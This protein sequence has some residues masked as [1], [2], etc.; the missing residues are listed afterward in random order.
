MTTLE[1]AKK[2]RAMRDAQKQYFKSRCSLD[3]RHAKKLESEIDKL[4]SDARFE[5]ETDNKQLS[6][7]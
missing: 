1:F 2:V 5:S 6:I 7:F 3:L 4:L